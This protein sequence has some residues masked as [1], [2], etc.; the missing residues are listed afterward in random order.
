M[1][2]IHRLR[3]T[4]NKSAALIRNDVNSVAEIRVIGQLLANRH[5]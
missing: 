4:N 3:M 1:I 2:L 5:A